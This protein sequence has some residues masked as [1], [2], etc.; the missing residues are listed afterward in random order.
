MGRSGRDSL[1]ILIAKPDALDQYFMAHPEELFQRSYEAA[2]LDPDNPY[3]LDAHLPCAASEMPL[4]LDDET[5]WPTDL[6]DHLE[7]LELKGT[8]ARSADGAPTW[9]S[10]RKRPHLHVNLRSI[11]ESFT[12]FENIPNPHL[13][14]LCTESMLFSYPHKLINRHIHGFYWARGYLMSPTMLPTRAREPASPL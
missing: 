3:V 14:R 1:V 11:G 8:L 12:I 5:Y 9:F 2:V 10:A 13:V 4:T 6:E 7:K